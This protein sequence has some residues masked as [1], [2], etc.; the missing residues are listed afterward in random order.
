MQPWI[1]QVSTETRTD[2][3]RLI[4]HAEDADIDTPI[5]VSPGAGATLQAIAREKRSEHEAERADAE[6]KCN[7]SYFL[8]FR[9]KV[10]EALAKL[11]EEKRVQEEADRVE[12]QKIQEFLS[13][14]GGSTQSEQELRRYCVW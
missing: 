9:R 8:F 6:Y 5:G 10:Q 4:A 14:R 1:G 11:Q 13:R 12:K 3:C 7:H 2:T